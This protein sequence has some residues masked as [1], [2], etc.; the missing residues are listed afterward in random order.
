MLTAMDW[1]LLG[2]LVIGSIEAA[3]IWTQYLSIKRLQS[4][5]ARHLRVQA[6]LMAKLEVSGEAI[7]RRREAIRTEL[8]GEVA[9]YWQARQKQ[10]QA[11]NRHNEWLEKQQK[12]YQV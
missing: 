5:D 2:G 12:P 8:R 7:R 10:Q 4:V 11:S 6:E 9:D 1:Y 3:I